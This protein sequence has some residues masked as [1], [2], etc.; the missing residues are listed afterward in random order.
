MTH[1]AE[2]VG[3]EL[4]DLDARR[5]FAKRLL[6]ERCGLVAVVPPTG[7]TPAGLVDECVGV[8][9]LLD[10]DGIGVRD[11]LGQG[12]AD[13]AG[14]ASSHGQPEL[15]TRLALPNG[16]QGRQRPDPRLIA[17][18]QFVTILTARRIPHHRSFER[19]VG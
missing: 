1:G 17:R 10:H 14:G 3:P 5:W 8:V 19:F 13:R 2:I 6:E 18:F 11:Q 4:V 7:M 16:L 9:G 12:R 15:E